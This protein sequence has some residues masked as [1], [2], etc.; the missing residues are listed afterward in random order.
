M[1]CKKGGRGDQGENSALI[2]FVSIFSGNCTVCMG[3]FVLKE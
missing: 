3:I 1:G 2:N